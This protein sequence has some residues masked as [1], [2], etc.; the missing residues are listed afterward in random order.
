[1]AF[2]T[3]FV[4]HPK[5]YRAAEQRRDLLEIMEDR[6]ACGSTVVTSQLPVE[7]WHET[8]TPPLP[9]PSSIGSC[10]MP[11]GSG[12]KARACAKRPPS[13]RSLTA[14]PPTDLM[15]TPTREPAL[16][17]GR[18]HRNPRPTSIGTGGRVH[19]ESPAD[20]VGMRRPAAGSRRFVSR[21]SV[22][23]HRVY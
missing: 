3:R 23:E 7:H 14:S 6:H 15:T 19:S 11:T 22:T 13:V 8:A 2:G 12:S 5:K 1:M 4:A 16:G 21:L 17:G 18:D 9:T 20:F 10:T